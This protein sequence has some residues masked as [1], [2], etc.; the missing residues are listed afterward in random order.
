M[1]IDLVLY[2]CFSFDVDVHFT[3]YIAVQCSSLWLCS[4]LSGSTFLFC[5]SRS[6]GALALSGSVQIDT[7]QVASF[8]INV[9]LQLCS[10][11]QV[12]VLMQVQ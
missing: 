10:W 2:T 7:D 3:N 5:F 6:A 4:L 1:I 9:C 8:N 12:I 11:I